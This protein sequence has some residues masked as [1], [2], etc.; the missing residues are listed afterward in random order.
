MK[1]YVG[2]RLF[3]GK[4]SFGQEI[5]FVWQT[6]IVN[7]FRKISSQNVSSQKQVLKDYED[8]FSQFN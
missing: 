7:Y 5:I 1:D 6:K 2:L 4:I 8:Y 3:F